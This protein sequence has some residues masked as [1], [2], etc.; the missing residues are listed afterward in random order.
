[1]NFCMNEFLRGNCRPYRGLILKGFGSAQFI[2]LCQK[3]IILSFCL[4][5]VTR[6][7]IASNHQHFNLINTNNGSIDPT[8]VLQII[9]DI[10]KS[11]SRWQFRHDSSSNGFP[12]ERLPAINQ[13]SFRHH[14]WS[15]KNSKM[16]VSE[17]MRKFTLYRL[18]C[19][20]FWQQN[21]W[22]IQI[23][24]LILSC[25]NSSRI[26]YCNCQ[27]LACFPRCRSRV[28]SFANSSR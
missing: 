22:R 16:T 12:P 6:K 7:P 3:D 25:K 13:C 24:K 26:T 1:M 20:C 27:L 2:N 23:Q 18:C 9:R 14:R 11:F 15:I 28:G 10:T 19:W 5:S 21:Y 8:W 4:R 17:T